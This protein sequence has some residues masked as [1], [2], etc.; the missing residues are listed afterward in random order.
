[1]IADALV[2]LLAPILAFTP[3]EIWK[4]LPKQ[5]GSPDS[6]HIAMFPND[7]EL[8][9]NLDAAASESWKTLAAVRVEVLKALE[10]ARAAKAIAG[11]LEARVEL[12]AE[13]ALRG[14]LEKYG[15]W[16]PALFIV[17]Q[18][19]L[20]S[21]AAADATRSESIAGLA[22]AVRRADGSKCER[23][24]NYST[25]VGESTAF[26]TVCERCL[27]VV[28]SLLGGAAAAS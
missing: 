22:V 20:V 6:V 28:E 24:W 3:E 4:H 16:L 19:S 18:V 7:A 26:P 5:A 25:H 14:V 21:Q 2:R 13:G 11:A 9:T 12:F 10:A 27:P 1:K 17:S 8:A 15:D 23:C